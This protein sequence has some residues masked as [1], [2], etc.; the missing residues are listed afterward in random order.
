MMDFYWYYSRKEVIDPAGK[1]NFFKAIGVASQVFNTLTEVI[2]GPCVGNQQT[3][4]HSRYILF[5][6]LYQC[7]NNLLTFIILYLN[8]LDDVGKLFSI[9]Q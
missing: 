3:L 7:S 2:Q 5:F 4:A 9:T 1:S 6:V 8:L